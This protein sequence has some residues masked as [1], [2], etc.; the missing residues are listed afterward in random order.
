MTAQLDHPRRLL[1]RRIRCRVQPDGTLL[2]TA[3]AEETARIWHVPGG[4]FARALTGQT[5]A[6]NDVAFDPGGTLH[7]DKTARIWE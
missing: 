1:Q 6:V 3:N 7:Y 2:P 4:T 5:H